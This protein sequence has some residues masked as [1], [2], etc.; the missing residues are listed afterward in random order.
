MHLLLAMVLTFCLMSTDTHSISL[1]LSHQYTLD[2]R[3]TQTI[4]QQSHKHL[5]VQ[6]VSRGQVN[7]RFH[8][9]WPVVYLSRAAELHTIHTAC[10]TLRV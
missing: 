3:L 7:H 6:S 5:H 4:T 1:S 8:R 2:N 9:P 10:Q